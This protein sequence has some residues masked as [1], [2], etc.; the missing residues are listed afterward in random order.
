MQ[1]LFLAYIVD[2]SGC[3][4]PKNTYAVGKPVEIVPAT[5]ADSIPTSVDSL[6]MNAPTI[7][8]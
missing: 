2:T 7:Q 4:G 1:Y 6:P 8:L 3:Y 5:G